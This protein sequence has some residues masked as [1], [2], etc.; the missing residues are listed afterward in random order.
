[1]LVNF[2]ELNSQELYLKFLEKIKN[3]YLVFVSSRKCEIRQFTLCL[4]GQEISVRCPHYR[5][6][7]LSGLNLEKM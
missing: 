1:M 7:V 5:V 3:G 2:C 4:I 6:S